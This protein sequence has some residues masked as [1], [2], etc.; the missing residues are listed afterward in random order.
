MSDRTVTN[1]SMKRDLT[2]T[3]NQQHVK[4][5]VNVADKANVLSTRS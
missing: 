5:C 4:K 1:T 2:N 3:E